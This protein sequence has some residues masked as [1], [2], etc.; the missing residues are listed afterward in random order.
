MTTTKKMCGKKCFYANGLQVNTD[1][2]VE[3]EKEGRRERRGRR[4]KAKCVCECCNVSTVK[5]RESVALDVEISSVQCPK[6]HL[7][8]SQVRDP[9]GAALQVMDISVECQVW[10]V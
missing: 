5:C 2:W 4:E 3:G 8:V 6:A 7:R 9:S 1:R 10:S